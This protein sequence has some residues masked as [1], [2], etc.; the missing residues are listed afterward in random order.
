M[1]VAGSLTYNTKIDRSGFEKGLDNLKKTTNTAGSQIKSIVTALGIDKLISAT[2]NLLSNSID[3]AV[4]RLDTLNNYPKV[5]SNL[6]ISTEDAQ[7]SINKMSD[8]LSGLPTTLDEGALSVQ[9]FTSANGDIEKSTDYF[10]ALN[11]AIL[12]GGASTDIQSSAMEQL[13]QAY[14]KGKPDMMEWR[15]LMTAMPAQLKQVAMAMGYVSTDALGEDLRNG[16]VSMN[17]FMDTIV[18]LNT[19]GTGEFQSFEEQAKNSTGGIATSI[20]VAK[21]QVV[22]GVAKIIQSLDQF[23]KDEGLGGIGEV[24]S[25]VGEKAKEML[26][27]IAEKLP[28]VIDFLKQIAP[29]ISGVIA[30][31]I[32]YKTILLAIKAIQFI[33]GIVGT[34]SAF[35]SLIPA[36]KGVKDAMLLLNMAFS[37]NPITLIVGLIAGL[38]AIL[39]VLYNKS[40]VFRKSLNK[41][42]QTIKDSFVK[43]WEKIKPSLEKL[44]ENFK[45]LLEKMKPVGDFLVNILGKAFEFL[46]NAISF[47]ID[48][49]AVV[50]TAFIDFNNFLI[51]FWTQT[52]PNAIQSFIDFI[53]QLPQKIWDFLVNGWNSI[54]SFFTET[55]P[56]WIQSVI[57]WFA[58]LPYAIGY[59]IG[60]ILGNIIK[61]GAS[62]WNWIT[63]E[64]PKI[65]Q[66]IIN[67]FAKLPARIWEWLC[68]VVKNV[69]TW[70]KNTYNTAIKWISD[71]VKGVVEWFKSL[72]ERVKIWLKNTINN[73]AI[74]G[75]NT[76]NTATTWIH[77][78]IKGVVS[79]FS[80]LPGRVWTWLVNTINN[81]VNWGQAMAN[82]GKEG[83]ENLFNNIVN[84]VK[85]LPEKMLE[86]GKNIVTGIW[87]GI[88]GMGDWFRGQVTGFFSG[89]VDGAKNSLGI[90]S[91][92]RVFRDKVGKFI[93]QG[94]AVGIEADT[95]K[96]TTAI[97]K[98]NDKIMREMQNA[99]AIETGSISAK[100]I[101]QSNK[102]QPI[103]IARD[104]IVHVDNTQNF[105]EKNTTPYEQ[106]K[107]AK[108]QLRRVAYGI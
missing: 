10:L 100:A 37:A 46:G 12:A 17:E 29:L 102:E 1:A 72:P 51:D 107:Q 32:V 67:W 49:L 35:I 96:A 81:V 4:S 39:V 44:G 38:I 50:I 86:I 20:N 36:I 105:Y 104:H 58:Q 97:D 42:F 7:K 73:I 40:E 70:G 60:Q 6:G 94:I 83:A 45:K 54:V 80:Q 74:W 63:T 55:I 13:S 66:G 11:N 93:P 52:V 101:L 18:R 15:S 85:E 43:A 23:L 65:I 108:Q 59:Q 25:N 95:K 16:K 78:T 34:V 56:Q 24:I 33:Q 19:E 99:V 79:W 90:H 62:V 92:S 30:G 57:D 82:K 87:N 77:N 41:A 68:N 103:V 14:A 75:E 91:P 9:R 48:I 98:M 28:T 84:V 26:S 3:G 69:V 71:T 89:I 8:K 5:M 61:F 106:Q 22:K 27:G 88:A 21:T 76:Y 2:F 31:L 53:S 47:I 64:L